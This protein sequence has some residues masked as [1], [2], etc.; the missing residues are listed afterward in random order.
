MLSPVK[1]AWATRPRTHRRVSPTRS[2]VLFFFGTG[3]REGPARRWITITD[4]DTDKSSAPRGG[5]SVGRGALN[6]LPRGFTYRRPQTRS[7]TYIVH[8]SA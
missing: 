2:P 4:D 7:P 5:G 1:L 3:F 8:T 6:L